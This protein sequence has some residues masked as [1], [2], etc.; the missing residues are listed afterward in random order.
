MSAMYPTVNYVF[1]TNLEKPFF[2]HIQKHSKGIAG[3]AIL[4]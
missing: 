3:I 1:Q 4:K 2:H